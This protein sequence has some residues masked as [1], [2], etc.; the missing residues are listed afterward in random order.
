M[1][2]ISIDDSTYRSIF[3]IATGFHGLHVIVWALFLTICHI[4]FNTDLLGARHHLGLA[5][6][7]WYWH[8]VDRA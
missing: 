8:F 3:F 5:A 7:I 2:R 6:A 1:G 4:P